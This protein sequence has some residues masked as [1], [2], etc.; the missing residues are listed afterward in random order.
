VKADLIVVNAGK[1]SWL[2]GWWNKLRGKQLC[3]E[4]DIPVL[5]VG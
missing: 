3:R 2:K 4:S 5:T 1:E